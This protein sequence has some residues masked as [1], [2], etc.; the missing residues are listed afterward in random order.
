MRMLWT[1]SSPCRQ[2]KV[3]GKL[4]G[5]PGPTHHESQISAQAAT[6]SIA[7][8]QMDILHSYKGHKTLQENLS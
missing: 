5:L 7:P 6:R 1:S 4:C 3:H 8:V 2:R